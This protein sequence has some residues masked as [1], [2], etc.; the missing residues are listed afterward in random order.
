MDLD[1]LEQRLV[2]RSIIDA[3]RIMQNIIDRSLLTDPKLLALP[4]PARTYRS[5]DITD[6]LNE[7]HPDLCRTLRS[8]S[9]T[10][11]DQANLLSRYFS[12]AKAA[13]SRS[14]R[15]GS[16]TIPKLIGI[17]VVESMAMLHALHQWPIFR[18]T[19]VL[20]EW[21]AVTDY[22]RIT[23]ENLALPYPALYL[24]C[25]QTQPPITLLDQETGEH[26]LEGAYLVMDR[27]P[28]LTK[29]GVCLIGAPKGVAT[30]DTVLTF[31]LEIAPEE[32]GCAIDEIYINA[33][34]TYGWDEH[35][36]P[37]AI[38]ALQWIGK[39]LLY[40]NCRNARLRHVAAPASQPEKIAALGPKKRA[41]MVRRAARTYPYILVGP[42][43][44]HRPENKTE[45][46]SG[47]RP[48]W[49]RGH[50]HLVC[51]GSGRS[52]RTLRYFEPVWVG[53]GAHAS[54][55]SYQIR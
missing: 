11:M 54:P 47:I 14:V 55:K 15:P 12:N 41:K 51:T 31:M 39:H 16:P 43:H 22:D 45:A 20:G 29:I 28:D 3:P 34:R 7:L 36:T 17:S 52:E 5:G 33:A 9:L 42:E 44:Q 35:H 26:V 37:H 6:M 8:G 27:T 38:R 2:T 48:H 13:V 32:S 24:S 46:R 53:G 23:G 50:M 49:R 25:A 21:L 30:N 1:H 10:V 40:I 18:S 4:H 19:H